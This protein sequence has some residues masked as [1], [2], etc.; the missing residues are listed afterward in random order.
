MVYPLGQGLPGCAVGSLDEKKAEVI[1]TL[2]KEVQADAEA[3]WDGCQAHATNPSDPEQF[4]Q[5]F[6]LPW[7]RLIL[8]PRFEGHSR[9]F[10]TTRILRFPTGTRSPATKL[11]WSCQPCSRSQAARCMTV[12]A[13]F[14]SMEA[15]ASIHRSRT[16]SNLDAL[17]EKFYID[18]PNG[19]L[20]F[21]PQAGHKPSFLYSLL[22]SGATWPL[23]SP[24]SALARCSALHHSNIL[25]R[26]WESWNR[27][28]NKESY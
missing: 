2:P 14:G 7:H 13:G 8:I 24:L 21:N 9:G 16:G 4:Q 25:D 20:G 11:I 6:F 3:V 18:G 28:G 27:L 17:N 12:R 1:A 26:L 5:W 22:A 10:C 19:S 15:D 23:I